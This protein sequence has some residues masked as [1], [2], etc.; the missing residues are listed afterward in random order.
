MLALRILSVWNTPGVEPLV[1]AALRDPD[2]ELR[3][4]TVLICSN[5]WYAACVPILLTM[6]TDIDPHV[7]RYLG[8]ALGASGDPRAIPKLIEL[9]H[10]Y[11]PDPYIKIWAAQGLGKFKRYEGVPVM[12][13]LLNDPKARDAEGNVMDV[14][15]ELTGQNF[16]ENRN[17][18]LEWWEKTGKA[19]YGKGN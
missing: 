18:W 17:A 1:A 16:G 11:D 5:H 4:N 10:D 14:L 7:R 3:A 19:Q 2:L 9:L 6:E 13:A 15:G 8:A 12:M